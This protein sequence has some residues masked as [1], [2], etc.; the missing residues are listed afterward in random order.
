[1]VEDLRRHDSESACHHADYEVLIHV[2]FL[3]SHPHPKLRDAS[4]N[5]KG[6][7]SVHQDDSKHQ[8]NIQNFDYKYL[9]VP[10]TLIVD[11]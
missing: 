9:K 7:C 3:R 11:K 2:S 1:M 8:T 6:S 4:Q 10:H 5:H